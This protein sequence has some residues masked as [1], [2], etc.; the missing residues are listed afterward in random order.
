LFGTSPGPHSSYE[1]TFSTWSTAEA[2]HLGARS[3][4]E[5]CGA[6]FPPHRRHRRTGDAISH[7]SK[8]A[9]AVLYAASLA[10]CLGRALDV[11]G[12]QPLHGHPSDRRASRRRRSSGAASPSR[13]A[14]PSGPDG[15]PKP[16]A[17]SAPSGWASA[18]RVYVGD[19]L[20]DECRRHLGERHDAA[21]YRLGNSSRSSATASSRQGRPPTS[22]MEPMDSGGGP[23][24]GVQVTGTALAMSMPDRRN[25]AIPAA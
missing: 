24:A 3:A 2:G 17:F 8:A 6:L 14:S 7:L 1:S 18:F 13:L 12:Q 16:S 21:K 20:R 22:P 5:S 19:A 25:A 10:D 11:R 15:R 23:S 9:S 4:A